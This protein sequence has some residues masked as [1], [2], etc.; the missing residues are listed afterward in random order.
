VNIL[1][2]EA[3]PFLNQDRWPES[4][5]S[6]FLT[7]EVLPAQVWLR[8]MNLRAFL[9]TRFSLLFGRQGCFWPQLVVMLFVTLE[10]FHSL[11]CE[12]DLDGLF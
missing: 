8:F 1:F 12:R 10:F 6:P 5:L 11:I 2:L 9:W 3:F 7:F 4:D